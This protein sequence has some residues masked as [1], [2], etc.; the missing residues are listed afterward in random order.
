MSYRRLQPFAA[1]PFA[2]LHRPD[3]ARVVTLPLPGYRQA[4]NYSCGFATA[5]MVA[6]H[7][8]VE[9]AAPE[10]Y[11]LVGTTYWGTSQ[12]A[13]VRALRQVGVRANIRYDVDFE[14]LATAIDRGKLVVGYLGD[15]EHWLVLYGY[16]RDPDRV[17]V[18]DPRP[19]Q[20][21][22]HPWDAYGARLGGFGIV[23]SRPR[24]EAEE[25]VSQIAAGPAEE[26]PCEPAPA[27][28]RQLAFEFGD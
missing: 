22:E 21:C 7:Y 17:Y 5:L 19:S 3:D 9:L 10:L 12:T 24:A 11:A 15:D 1:P 27:P 26:R 14:R 2:V 28:P 16:G 23:C 6:R 18:A 8:G 4:K 13:L 20:G 25:V